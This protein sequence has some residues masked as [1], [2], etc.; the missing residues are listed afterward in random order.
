[1]SRYDDEEREDARRERDAIIQEEARLLREDRERLAR[2]Q[3]RERER[4]RERDRERARRQREHEES[5]RAAREVAE[6]EGR[7]L[8]WNE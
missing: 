3:E 6:R 5:L 1:V 8:R 4:E 7:E 2:E